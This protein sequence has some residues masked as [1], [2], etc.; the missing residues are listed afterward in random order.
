MD[1]VLCEFLLN[2]KY[3]DHNISLNDRVV[4]IAQNWFTKMTDRFIKPLKFVGSHT[5]QWHVCSE[6]DQSVY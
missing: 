2:S 3:F 6:G 1:V 5:L 4:F